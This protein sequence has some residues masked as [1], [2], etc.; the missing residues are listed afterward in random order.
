MEAAEKLKISAENLNSM[1]A[2]SL[3]KISDTRKRTKKLKAVSILRRR[4]KKK[5]SKIEVPSVFKKSVSKIKN[6]VAGG[7]GNLFGNILGF[8]SLLLL[9]V[10]ITNIEM[11]QEKLNDARKNLTKKLKPVINVAKVIFE[12]ARSFI[13][14]FETKDREKEYQQLLEDIQSLEKIKKDF[15]KI[16]KNSEELEKTY[17]D[18]ES[19]KYAKKNN[20]TLSREGSLSDGSTYTYDADKKEY[21]V[22]TGRFK[23]TLTFGEFFNKYSESDIQNIIKKDDS[24]LNKGDFVIG[25]LETD[26]LGNNEV[27]SN[28]NFNNNMI[29]YNGRNNDFLMDFDE[30]LFSDNSETYYIQEIYRDGG[31]A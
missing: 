10:A 16:G 9:G 30:S 31:I 23:K 20:I 27:S 2:T 22:S 25:G 26:M 7:T 21:T 15:S 1:L 24:L 14:L 13:S 5:E 11:I 3:Q 8:V 18:V 17:K 29:A 4:R 19:G 28:N 6:K 12:G